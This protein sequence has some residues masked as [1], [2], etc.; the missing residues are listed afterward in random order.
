MPW[1]VLPAL[2]EHRMRH[3]ESSQRSTGTCRD[4]VDTLLVQASAMLRRRGS[5][6]MATIAALIDGAP[7]CVP[8]VS[9]LTRLDA[10]RIYAA[11]ERLKADNS[12]HVDT[13]VCTRCL[14]TTMVHTIE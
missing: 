12:V 2:D 9:L 8:C 7:H 1:F 5:E 3:R 4:A 11:I 10:R 6:D 14:R 13:R